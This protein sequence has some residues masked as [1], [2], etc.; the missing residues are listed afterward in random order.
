MYC[1]NASKC[2]K[3]PHLHKLIAQLT[4]LRKTSSESIVYYLTRADDMQH[5]LTLVNE[6]ISEKMLF[7][8][9]LNGLPKEF[10]NFATIVKYSKDEK[11]LE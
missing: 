3:R 4:S 2:F 11:T 1:V 5:N 10:E 9:I 6:G 8:I 7:S